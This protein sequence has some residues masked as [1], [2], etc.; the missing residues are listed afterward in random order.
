MIDKICHF[1][2]KTARG[3]TIKNSFVQNFGVLFTGK[4]LIVTIGFLF[5]PVIARVYTPEE[6]GNYALFN[7]A[8]QLLSLLALLSLPVSFPVIKNDGIFKRVLNS[9]VALSFTFSI[10]VYIVTRLFGSKVFEIFNLKF[11][12]EFPVLLAAGTLLYCFTHILGNWNVREKIYAKSSV[13]ALG[14]ALT[15]KVA[16]L[17]FG[18]G[19]GNHSLG[20]IFGEL[21]GKIVHVLIQKF[22]ALKS[23]FNQ[24][25]SCVNP[26]NIIW[27]VKEYKSYPLFILPS[28]GLR[29]FSGHLIIF[30]LIS[31][32]G[33]SYGGYFTMAGALVSIPGNLMANILQP[34]ILQK[35]N[36]YQEDKERMISVTTEITNKLIFLCIV[37][38]SILIGYGDLILEILL[39]SQW[40]QAGL[41]IQV[42]SVTG[43]FQLLYASLSGILIVA[44][45]HQDVLLF[46]GI[47][48]ALYAF[49]IFLTWQFSWSF[50][51]TIVAYVIATFLNSLTFIVYL[52]WK[53]GVRDYQF[54]IKPL[55]SFAVLALAL[56]LTRLIIF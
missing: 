11:F 19:F 48:I 28:T 1:V 35:T 45:R 8:V 7:S 13:V 6:Y 41:I 33:S 46:S 18:L 2:Y 3:L 42:L 52:F 54:L 29:Q 30:F 24:I 20:L 34:L 47:E 55:F 15:S 40:T 38:F 9:S 50:Q 12:P 36:D 43:L 53:I 5:T 37:P 32:F 51:E 17:S 26:T 56:L 10:A 21:V 22:Y 4:F 14:E 23:K 31:Q 49:I 39:G 44:K 25:F 16:T 27:V